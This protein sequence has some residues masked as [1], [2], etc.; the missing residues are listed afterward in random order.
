MPTL[1][2]EFKEV[3]CAPLTI[4]LSIIQKSIGTLVSTGPFGIKFAVIEKL[5]VGVIVI[6]ALVLLEAPVQLL[7]TKPGFAIAFSFTGILLK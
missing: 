6:S 7:K 1:Y 4:A 5:P 3:N 2:V